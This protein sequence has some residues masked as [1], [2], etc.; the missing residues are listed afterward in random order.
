M[1]ENNQNG[2]HNNGNGNMIY[3]IRVR[4]G[5]K[6]LEVEGDKEFVTE[7][8]LNLHT[9]LLEAPTLQSLE[10][11]DII[12]DENH[13]ATITAGKDSA[14]SSSEIDRS[15]QPP[16]LTTF[17]RKSDA[18]THPDK[19]LVIAA[20]LYKYRDVVEFTKA[21]I[22]KCYRDAL[23]PKSTNVNRDIN[24]NR[25]KGYFEI[26]GEEREGL[27]TFYITAEGLDTVESMMD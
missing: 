21:D 13:E 27:M 26:T 18:S 2:H 1:D 4:I 23:L 10:T 11:S 25:T 6:E 3:R 7:T 20:Y 5:E 17:L 24:S 9:R 22:D 19:V 8:C 16:S 12:F 14:L 15:A